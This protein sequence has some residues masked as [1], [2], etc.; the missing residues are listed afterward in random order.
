MPPHPQIFPPL[1]EGAIAS[2]DYYDFASGVGYKSFYPAD[3]SG[4][5]YTLTTETI[6]SHAGYTIGAC[7]LD[8][9]IEFKRACD[10]KGDVLANIPCSRYNSTGSGVTIGY[11]IQVFI[12]HWDGTTET[13]MANDITADNQTSISPATAVSQIDALKI[14]ITTEK[15]FKA[16]DSLRITLK[17]VE[18]AGAGR[19]YLGHDPKNRTDIFGAITILGKGSQ[20]RI[21]VPFK[22]NN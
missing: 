7:D 2:Y 8:F 4:P 17:L 9:D 12:R 19:N 21:S 6:Y 10:V 3:F 15:H 5:L 18:T 14:P 20:S 22:L 13:E 1:P 16:G 11:T